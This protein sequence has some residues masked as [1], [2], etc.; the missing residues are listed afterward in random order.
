MILAG[1]V[2]LLTRIHAQEYVWKSVPIDGS[3]T[4]CTASAADNVDKTIGVIGQD[5][6][7]YSPSGKKFSPSSSTA[8][9]AAI[10][11]NAQPEMVDLKRVV[12][13][14]AAKMQ[15]LRYESPLSNWFVGLI[16]DK[17]SAL[18]GKKCHVGICNFGGIRQ[19]MP[20]GKVLL[21]DIQSMFPFKNYLVHLQMKGIELRKVFESM[22]QNGFQAV[23]GVQIEV[24]DKKLVSVMSDG[25]PLD[26]EKVYDV[27]TISFLLDGGD[28]L[29]LADSSL[30]VNQYDVLI[31]DAVLEHV[32]TL[33]AEGKLITS[34]N[35]QYV[36][37]R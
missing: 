19:G 24:V 18:S 16:M 12:A 5:G 4:G 34:P 15:R 33:T 3:L 21:D 13:Y 23:A 20:K 22:A 30:S 9:V 31:S 29:R 17:V 10:V 6:S 36:V 2:V 1:M 27:A 37:I 14:S 26:D 28:G 32:N 11:L 8:K 35:V 7:Y 25:Q